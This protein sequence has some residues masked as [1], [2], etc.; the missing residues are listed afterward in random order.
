MGQKT[1]PYGFRLGVTK[2]WRSRW[3]AKQD[4]AKLL[5]ED[6]ELKASLRDRLKAA[7]HYGLAGMDERARSIGGTLELQRGAA[8]GAVVTVR[9]P[10]KGGAP[11]DDGV[12][13]VGSGRPAVG[14]SRFARGRRAGSARMRA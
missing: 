5:H 9:V 8:G 13:L 10:V 2:T 7:G 12:G 1:H 3:F 4:Y 14:L 6:L 11:P